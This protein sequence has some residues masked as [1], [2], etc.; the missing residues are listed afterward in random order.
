MMLSKD[1]NGKRHCDL[2]DV[3]LSAEVF[4]DKLRQ[5]GERTEDSCGNFIQR[6]IRAQWGQARKQNGFSGPEFRQ[7]ALG[8]TNG[9]F[10]EALK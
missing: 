6:T 5:A 8:V 3:Y 1:F 10:F 4:V 7:F 2:R 9:F